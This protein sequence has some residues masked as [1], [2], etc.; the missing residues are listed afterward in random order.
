M[1]A[2]EQIIELFF[3]RSEDA[4]SA[5]DERYGKTCRSISYNI[6]GSIEDADECVNDAYLGTWNA[7]PPARPNPLLTFVAKIVRNISLNRY[8]HNS[9]AMRSS[10]CTVAFEELDACLADVKTLDDDIESADLARIIEEFLNTLSAENRLL[11]MRRY[12]F[13]DSIRDIAAMTGLSEKNVSVR[14][15][16]IRARMRD[17]LNSKEVSV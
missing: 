5:L 7:I 8:W 6:V 11:F 13:S 2:D 1:T 10:S 17:Y 9:A 4:I 14:L 3:A 15:T 16:R 12:W